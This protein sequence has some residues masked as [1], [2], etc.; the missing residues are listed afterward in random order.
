MEASYPNHHTVLCTQPVHAQKP[1]GLVSFS[2][3]QP[4][5]YY[6]Q[7]AGPPNIAARKGP[8]TPTI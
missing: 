6:L 1:L 4:S 2:K 5:V 8:L 3:T 7:V